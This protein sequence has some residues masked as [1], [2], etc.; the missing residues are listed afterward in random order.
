MQRRVV[1]ASDQPSSGGYVL[2]TNVAATKTIFK[3]QAALIVSLAYCNSCRS[4]APIVK[5]GG[6]RRSKYLGKE[7]ALEYDSIACKCLH[8]P[9]MLSTS[10]NAISVEDSFALDP[11]N[12]I[13]LAASQSLPRT[14][15]PPDGW[16]ELPSG[17]MRRYDSAGNAAYDID[18]HADHGAGTP[19]GHNWDNGVR[20]PGV[21]LSIIPY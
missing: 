15:G 21:P 2:S 12:G 20:S 16:L 17:Q 8:R 19:H 1:T 3:A 10:Q 7:V 11:S 4:Y 6:P 14:G 9:Y 18:F 5:S 13:Q